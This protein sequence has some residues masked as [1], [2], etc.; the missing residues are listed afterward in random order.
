MKRLGRWLFNLAAGVSLVLTVVW[1]YLWLLPA[2]QPVANSLLWP[3]GRLT[4][5]KGAYPDTVYQVGAQSSGWTFARISQP[6]RGTP[7]ISIQTF[8][9]FR[10]ERIESRG[11]HVTLFALPAW[12]VLLLTCLLPGLWLMSAVRLHRERQ[13]QRQGFCLVCGY[14]LRA[15]PDRCPECGILVEAP[16]KGAAS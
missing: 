8:C 4:W 10:L 11:G 3:S 2:R 6:A 12:F 1:A 9:G 5:V 13:R 14:D 15:T 16:G 7:S